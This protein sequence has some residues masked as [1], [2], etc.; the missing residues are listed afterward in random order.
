MKEMEKNADAFIALPGGYG[1][2]E[3]ILEMVA[4]SQFWNS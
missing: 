1:T 4:W 2:M 3:E